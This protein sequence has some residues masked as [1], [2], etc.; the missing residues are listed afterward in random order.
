MALA[1][2]S[3]RG[4][5]VVRALLLAP[6]LLPSTAYFVGLQAFFTRAGLGDTVLAVLLGHVIVI[7]PYGVWTL[8]DVLGQMGKGLEEQAVPWGL[9]AP[10]P[11]G[12]LPC[13][14]F[15][16]PWA[17]V[18]GLGFVISFGQYFLTLML[19]GRPGAHLRHAGGALYP[20]GRPAAFRRLFLAFIAICAG[21]YC[22]FSRILQKHYREPVSMG[23][24]AL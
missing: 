12:I 13:P 19:G 20:G 24:G 15:F 4:K 18:T 10:P 22:L 3:F 21:V 17:A 5:R 6:V 1:W 8:T 14:S 11:C 2:H 16:P 7:L 9:R 23:K